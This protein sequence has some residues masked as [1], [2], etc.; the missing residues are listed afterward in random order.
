M[1]TEVAVS[2]STPADTAVAPTSAATALESFAGDDGQLFIGVFGG[3][4][5][6]GHGAAQFASEQIP[7]VIACNPAVRPPTDAHRT[8]LRAMEQARELVNR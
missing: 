8:M 2:P 5:P 3:R 6:N 1:R 7:R 4:G